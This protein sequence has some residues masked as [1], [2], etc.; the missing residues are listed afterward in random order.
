MIQEVLTTGQKE[1][2]YKAVFRS[3]YGRTIVRKLRDRKYSVAFFWNS[4]P[5]QADRNDV[6][7]Y[8][9]LRHAM[10]AAHFLASDRDVIT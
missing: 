7:D 10:I 2:G 3:T 8:A 6:K 5:L 9:T 1:C 4:S